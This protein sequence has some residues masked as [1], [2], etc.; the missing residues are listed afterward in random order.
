LKRPTLIHKMKKLGITR[1]P[2]D[3]ADAPMPTFPSDPLPL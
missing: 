2:P 3:R 1:P